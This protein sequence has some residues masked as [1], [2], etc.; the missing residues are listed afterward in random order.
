MGNLKIFDEGTSINLYCA[1]CTNIVT[2]HINELLTSWRSWN[3]EIC[4]KLRQ[5]N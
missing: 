2:Q 5:N 1:K 3:Q 4:R